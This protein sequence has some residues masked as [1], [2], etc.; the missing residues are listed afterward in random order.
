MTSLDDI[1]LRYQRASLGKDELQQ[2][3]EFQEGDRRVEFLS[4]FP[5]SPSVDKCD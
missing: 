1:G 4:V 2:M 3:R 5:V